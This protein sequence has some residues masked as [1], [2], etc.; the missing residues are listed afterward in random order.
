MTPREIIDWTLQKSGWGTLAELE[1]KKWI[2]CQPEF[3]TG[4]LRQRLRLSGQEI[5]LQA[6]LAER[7]G[8][9]QQRHGALPAECRRCPTI[10]T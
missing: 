4:A 9:A 6:G 8:A 7:A 10:G 5:P 3:D 1:D 2:D